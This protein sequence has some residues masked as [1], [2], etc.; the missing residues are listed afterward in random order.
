MSEIVNVKVTSIEANPMRR[1]AEYPYSE[2]KI[3]ALRA[4]IRDVG[5][6]EGVIARKVGH[7]YQIAF[8]HH[9]I[10]AQRREKGED[11]RVPL[12]VRDLSDKEMLG[13]MGR[14]NLEDY[15]ADFLCMLES[16][17]AACDFHGGDPRQIKQDVEIAKLLGWTS[18]RK[19][20][21]LPMINETAAACSNAK[22]LID[23]G[24]IKKEKLAGLTVSN[25]REICQHIAHQHER[26]E[27]MAKHTKRPAA[28][29][30]TA[31]KILANSGERVAESVRAGKTA[32]KDIRGAIDFDAYEHAKET[33]AQAPLFSQFIKRLTSDLA[34]MLHSDR[35]AEKLEQIKDNLANIELEE[36]AKGVDLV[37]LEC[38]HLAKRSDKWSRAMVVPAKKIAQLRAVSKK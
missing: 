35:A 23:Q 5:L 2:T 4:S 17:E 36:D 18:L 37:S 19:R 30:E 34:E 8:G 15:N 33:K 10:E 22:R 16:W 31:K 13:F 24:Y 1:L 9:R 3:E 27:A 25:A 20:D 14:E 7:R 26:L 32:V 11:S 21:G 28:E 29:T 12:I 38:A 6:W